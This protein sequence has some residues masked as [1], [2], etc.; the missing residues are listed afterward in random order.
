MK[1]QRSIS[2]AAALA[3]LMLALTACGGESTSGAPSSEPSAASAAPAGSA[4]VG[5]SAAP[6]ASAEPT[7]TTPPAAPE[8]SS[9]ASAEPSAGQPEVLKGTGVYNGQI[10][11]HSI[12]IETGEGPVAFELGA[13]TEN[14][15]DTLNEQDKVNFE[16][17]E[18][19]VQGDASLKQRVLTKLTKAE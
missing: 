7:A 14:V 15:P 3:V 2:A 1:P 16:Y 9:P 17:V 18:K 13:G 8:P 4:A 10:D 19:D 11:N 5:A 12:E 6:T